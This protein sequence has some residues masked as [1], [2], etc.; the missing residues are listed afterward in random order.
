LPPSPTGSPGLI[1][2][3]TNHPLSTGPVLSHLV[4]SVL[5]SLPNCSCVVYS[6]PSWWRQYRP[7]KHQSTSTRLHNTTSQK[8]VIFILTVVRTWN[9]TEKFCV[10]FEVWI[11]S[12]SNIKTSFGFKG[13]IRIGV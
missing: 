13:L 9:L 12:L 11:E 3:S 4:Q 1:F 7:L 10:F 8:T 6:L 2:S 5:V